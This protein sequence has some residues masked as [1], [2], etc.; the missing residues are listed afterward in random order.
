MFRAD[1]PP[2]NPPSIA[3]LSKPEAC[4]RLAGGVASFNH[5]L[6]AGKPSRFAGKYPCQPAHGG[7]ALIAYYFPDSQRVVRD[8]PVHAQITEPARELWSINGIDPD[9]QA[10]LVRK[11]NGGF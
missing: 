4:Q 9:F 5:R 1:R 2:T 8:N 3:A 10:P 11:A 7:A 6:M